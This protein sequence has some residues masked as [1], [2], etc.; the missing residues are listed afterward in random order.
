MLVMGWGYFGF[1]CVAASEVGALSA[2]ARSVV[3]AASTGTVAV[4]V[5]A[6][7]VAEAIAGSGL[8][9]AAV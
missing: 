4:T 9:A 3:L 5:P 2:L 1:F 7:Y 8:I 6:C